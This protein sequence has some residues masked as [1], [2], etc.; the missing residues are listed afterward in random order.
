MAIGREN[1]SLARDNVDSVGFVYDLSFFWQLTPCHGGAAL[2]TLFSLLL[3]HGLVCTDDALLLLRHYLVAHFA[4]LVA[5]VDG[6]SRGAAFF[7][8]T[9]PCSRVA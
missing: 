5:L 2:L 8:A 1:L 7:A 3:I 4:E 6:L 9:G